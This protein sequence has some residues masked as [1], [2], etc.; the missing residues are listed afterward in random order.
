MGG[1]NPLNELKSTRDTLTKQLGVWASRGG[2]QADPS[3]PDFDANARDNYLKVRNELNAVNQ[4]IGKLEREKSRSR[5]GTAFNPQHHEV[6]KTI[7]G[8]RIYRPKGTQK[9]YRVDTGHNSYAAFKTQK[10]AEAYIKE[11]KAK[12]NA[13]LSGEATTRKITT[14][15]YERAKRRQ[16]KEIDNM[17]KK[18]R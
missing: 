1:G 11:Q 10:A 18:R 15:T 3:H 5:G 17:F 13:K 8:T 6:V 7:D 2:T 4:K 9:D 14:G 16:K 12:A